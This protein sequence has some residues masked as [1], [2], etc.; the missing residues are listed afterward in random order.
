[1]V[2]TL[3]VAL[4]QVTRLDV[5]RGTKGNAG[6]G[7][8]IGGSV[9]GAAGLGLSILFVAGGCEFVDSSGCDGSGPAVIAIGTAITFGAGALL[10]AVTGAFIKSDRWEEVPVYQPRVSFAPQRDGRFSLGLSVAF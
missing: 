6:K 9:L 1:M 5:H 2:D 8:L 4:T 10:G 7:A 3:R